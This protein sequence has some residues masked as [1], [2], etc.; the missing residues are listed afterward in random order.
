MRWY[1]IKM[2]PRRKAR[3][4]GTEPECGPAPLEQ[5]GEGNRPL[6]KHRGLAA[7][8]SLLCDD[9]TSC[10]GPLPV[11][12]AK[13]G[14]F[15]LFNSFFIPPFLGNF[16]SFF[17]LLVYFNHRRG[18]QCPFLSVSVQI[19]NPVWLFQ[20]NQC[21]FSVHSHWSFS[22]WVTTDSRRGTITSQARRSIT[23]AFV[24]NTPFI[25]CRTT[26]TLSSGLRMRP[27]SAGVLAHKCLTIRAKLGY[28][29]RLNVWASSMLGE[30]NQIWVWRGVSFIPP[31]RKYE[32]LQTHWLINNILFLV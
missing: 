32:L 23:K 28:Y 20:R 26:D 6:V 16:S 2:S 31:S 22:K 13:L 29:K 1:R 11:P 12:Q 27:F 5:W 24:V 3:T 8:P 10:Q 25:T 14:A 9:I 21:F 30:H 17:C 18:E 7:L 4:H 19:Y 15:S